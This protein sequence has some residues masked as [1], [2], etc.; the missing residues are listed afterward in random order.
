MQAA[1]GKRAAAAEAEKAERQKDNDASA[2]GGDDGGQD[3]ISTKDADVIFVRCLAK[4][5]SYALTDDEQ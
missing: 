1:K 4:R 3:L 5:P 2:D